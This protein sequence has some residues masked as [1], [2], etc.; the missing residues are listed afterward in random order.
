MLLNNKFMDRKTAFRIVIAILYFI[1][2][3]SVFAD[4]PGDSSFALTVK[5]QPSIPM[6]YSSYLFRVVAVTGVI[7]GLLLLIGLGIKKRFIQPDKSSSIKIHSKKYIGP[8]QYLTIIS[9]ED[10]HIL[11][12]VTEQSI[13]YLTTLESITDS[14]A[15]ETL[16]D[17]PFLQ[18]L[19][20]MRSR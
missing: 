6:S 18:I 4:T 16:A 1:C 14:T 20:K 3:T 7:A 2:V 11:L 19:N 9:T 10:K 13:S 12:G 17:T 15:D 8:K 5:E